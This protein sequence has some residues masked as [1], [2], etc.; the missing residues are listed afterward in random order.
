MIVALLVQ[1]IGAALVIASGIIDVTASNKGIVD[2]VLAYA[3]TRSIAHHATRD[4]NP[5]AGD[6]AAVKRGL[7]L[8]R[9]DCASCHGGPGTEPARF[10]A[11]LHPHAPDLGHRAV[12]SSFTDGMF[13]EAVARGIGSTG[14]PAF[15]RTH[16]PDEIWSIVAFLRHLPSLTP[17]EKEELGRR[18][19]LQPSPA[20]SSAASGPR[21]QRQGAA[22]T[23]APNGPGRRVH[24]V[25]ISDFKFV[26]ATLEVH[27]G[28]VVE[29]K[30]TDLVAHTATADDRTFDT[31]RIDGGGAKR[32][33][34]GRE[35]RFPYYCRYHP[36]MKGTLIV[37]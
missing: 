6:P 34:V 7:A 13:Y 28:D 33:V 26:P 24:E 16:S 31:G 21:A 14:M 32:L 29:W 11:G 37:R 1:A 30:N 15:G 8:Y 10:A 12:Q 2:R 20:A 35:G 22:A 23:A 4:R 3:S 18:P 25:S 5:L 9:D 19:E 36:E 17:G 27:L